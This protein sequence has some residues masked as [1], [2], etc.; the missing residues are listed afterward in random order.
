MENTENWIDPAD[1]VEYATAR[2]QDHVEYAMEGEF[3]DKGD[4]EL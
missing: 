2:D 1:R 4:E 3:E